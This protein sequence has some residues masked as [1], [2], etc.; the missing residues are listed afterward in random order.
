MCE[1]MK[2]KGQITVYLALSFTI[3]VSLFISVYDSARMS[4]AGVCAKCLADS[5]LSSSFAEYNKELLEQYDLMFVDLSYLSNSPSPDNIARHIENFMKEEAD[6]ANNNHF[7]W[8]NDVT[9][10]S[11]ETADIKGYRL[12]SDN[13]GY[14]MKKQAVEYM[15]S[16]TLQDLPGRI[17]GEVDLLE[18]YGINPDE[19]SKDLLSCSEADEGADIDNEW[20]QSVIKQEM[21][22]SVSDMI[23][24][25]IG[26]NDMT[27][28]V[29]N[30]SDTTMFRSLNQG[31]Y[32]NIGSYFSPADEVLFNEYIMFKFS[33]KTDI[34]ENHY[35]HMEAEY[36]IGGFPTD[37]TNFSQTMLEIYMIRMA[38]NEITLNTDGDLKKKADNLG[39][40][41]SELTDIPKPAATEIVIMIWSMF[42]SMGDMYD[43][44]KNIRVPLIKSGDE[45]QFDISNFLQRKMALS[46]K[47]GGNVSKGS[48]DYQNKKYGHGLDYEEYLRILLF[49]TNPIVKQYR[50]M[51]LIEL[52]LRHSGSGNEF[53]R[54]DSCTDMIDVEITIESSYGYRFSLKRKYAY[55]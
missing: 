19:S 25:S 8:V 2:V 13:C 38:A 4:C 16:L 41:L 24:D 6:L 18:S 50:T 43:I 10:F 32:G 35:M 45:I 34:I 9:G 53:F 52:N 28:H 17:I 31:T 36:V 23:L 26:D 21:L 3:M 11:G 7:L 46:D 44:G 15:Q 30:I 51:D 54:M 5:A 37:F 40:I 20:S 49:M 29:I 27:E 48:P 1:F 55:F 47:E 22:K 33:N 12:A 42:E 14:Y 39:S